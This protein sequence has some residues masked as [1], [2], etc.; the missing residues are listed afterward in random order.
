MLLIFT[1]VRELRCVRLFAAPWI[2]ALQ[3]HL[4]IEFSRQQY[5]SGLPFPP[6][7]DLPNPG[8]E[9][10]SLASPVLADKFFTTS[11]T[12][13]SQYL[14]TAIWLM[15]TELFPTYASSG[16]VSNFSSPVIQQLLF[17]VFYI[18]DKV[19]YVKNFVESLRSLLIFFDNTIIYQKCFVL[20]LFTIIMHFI[21][22]LLF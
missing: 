7:E 12:W 13:E 6:S 5:R 22:V 17:T 1:F 21:L 11:T 14:E 19:K 10:V 18:Y 9:P 2:V 20:F 4:S 16:N 3:A 8:I 15:R